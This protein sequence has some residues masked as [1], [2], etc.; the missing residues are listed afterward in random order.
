[1]ILLNW[2]MVREILII[3]EYH[4]LIL[5]QNFITAGSRDLLGAVLGNLLTGRTCYCSRLIG[6]VQEKVV[7]VATQFRRLCM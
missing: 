3:G 7:K 4:F 1:M 6:H 5:I 2:R